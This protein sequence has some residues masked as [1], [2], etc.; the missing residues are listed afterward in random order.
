VLVVAEAGG[1]GYSTVTDGGGSYVIFNVPDGS[2]TVSGY[3]I[4][5]QYSKADGVAVAGA[6][7]DGV[8]LTAMGA[9]AGKLT[10]SLDYV[11]G[12]PNN[13]TAVVLQLPSTM[14]VPPGFQAPAMN[15]PYSL[16]GLPDGTYNVLA[17]YPNDGLVKDP[18]T[19]LGNTGTPTVTFA[20]GNT[21]DAG[22]F[23]VTGPVDM[24]GPDANQVVMGTPTFTWMAYSSSGL[25]H[26][27]VFDS[28]G[29]QIWMMDTSATSLA[30]G[31]PALISGEFYKWHL[32]AYH[33]TD[34][35]REISMTE[36]LRGVWQEK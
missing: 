20:G 23:K 1:K 14:E 11:A 7:K 25:Y 6:R 32:I 35:S 30:Y 36:D 31:G 12:A 13:Q 3:F 28:Q 26:L 19:T 10:G 15:G 16:T 33:A 9:A 34:T 29:N 17:A 18:D 27:Q 2:Y 5:V 21:V 24:I 4:G 22:Q 8:N